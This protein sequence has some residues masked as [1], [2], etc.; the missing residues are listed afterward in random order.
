MSDTEAKPRRV[1]FVC[2]VCLASRMGYDDDPR[3]WC[4]R[5]DLRMVP[6]DDTPSARYIRPA[7]CGRTRGR[8]VQRK[9]DAT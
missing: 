7:G 2:N 6:D 8:P 4:R 9:V 3:P 1:E 5:C